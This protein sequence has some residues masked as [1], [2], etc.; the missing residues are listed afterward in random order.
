MNITE[1][2]KRDKCFNEKTKE[3]P[4]IR[5]SDKFSID[6]SRR[7][8]PIFENFDT[9]SQEKNFTASEDA[10]K[11][12]CHFKKEGNVFLT[13]ATNSCNEN[14]KFWNVSNSEKIKVA[15]SLS[16]P[17]I[18]SSMTIFDIDGNYYLAVGNLDDIKIW[19]VRKNKLDYTLK[20]HSGFINGLQSYKSNGKNFLVSSSGNTI[21]L[22][23][24][25]SKKCVRTF[26]ISYWYSFE[27]Y[28]KNRKTFL[29][30][31]SFDNVKLCDLDSKSYITKTIK[32]NSK[33][34]IIKV[35][36]KD[37]KPYLANANC[38]IKIW[39][40]NDYQPEVTLEGHMYS[41]SSLNVIRMKKTSCLVSGSW[42]KMKFWDLQKY[43]LLKSFNVP[44][45]M[46]SLISISIDNRSYIF[47]GHN[48]G[49]V[50]VW[51][52]NVFNV[53]QKFHVDGCRLPEEVCRHIFC[54]L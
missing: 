27:V 14:V 8:K 26:D 33:F 35:F 9:L 23:N 45:T 49:S 41:I 39:N 32:D 7:D 16:P 3:V 10:V 42:N 44:S 37:G 36:Y 29:A 46:V 47:S 20:G 19:D 24:I 22:W 25:S 2:L 50:I 5:N 21:K 18:V 13:S 52:D 34:Q 54:F 51:S 11:E 38:M 1:I 6:N 28:K 12:L 30:I 53:I 4:K 17:V 43:I 15:R 40:L 48:N 31:G